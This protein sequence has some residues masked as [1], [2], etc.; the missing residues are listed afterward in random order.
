[1]TGNAAELAVEDLRMRLGSFLLDGVSFTVPARSYC[2]LVGAPGSGKTV[3]A[4]IICGLNRPAAGRVVLGGE[5]ITRLD[6]SRRQIGYVPQDYALLPQR[7]VEGN[8]SLGR[9]ARRWSRA[10]R[11]GRVVEIAEELGIAHLLARQVRGLSG[12]EK[13][14]VALGRALVF[15]PRLLVLDEPVSALDENTRNALLKLLKET[16]RSQDVTTLHICHN[17]DEMMRVA[18]VVGVMRAGRIEQTGPRDEVLNRP[19]TPFVAEFLQAGNILPGRARTTGEGSEITVGQLKL[20]VPGRFEGEVLVVV[21]P[22]HIALASPDDETT[23]KITSITD[24]GKTVHL[25]V[26]AGPAWEVVMGKSEFTRRRLTVGDAVRLEI[27]SDTV[28]VI[29]GEK[30]STPMNRDGTCI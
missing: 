19:K 15:S 10:R 24:R 11:R 7:S 9:E 5:D 21:R 16:Q 26:E 3:I 13:Q 17:F 27:P 4:E 20:T 6:P 25:E 22:E 1:M 8:L 12:G 30:G 23:G 29:A 18:E 28:H 2:V 14:R